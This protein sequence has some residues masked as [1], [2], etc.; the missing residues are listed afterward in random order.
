VSLL[1]EDTIYL[2]NRA[3][4]YLRLSGFSAQESFAYLQALPVA[5]FAAENHVVLRTSLLQKL[6]HQNSTIHS[7]P[8]QAPPTITRGHMGY[9]MG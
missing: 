1:N 8:L 7:L 6:A 2:F 3:Y 5:L 4:C 9:G